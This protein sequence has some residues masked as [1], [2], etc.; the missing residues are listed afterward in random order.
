MH[1]ELSILALAAVVFIYF[2]VN[3]RRNMVPEVRNEKGA[4]SRAYF[5]PRK[6]LTETGRRHRIGAI[7]TIAASWLL[8]ELIYQL[9]HL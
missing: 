1:F 2:N 5:S 7:V 8:S 3:M 9:Y 6:Y 4:L